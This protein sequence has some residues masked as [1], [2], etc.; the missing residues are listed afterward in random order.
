MYCYH[1]STVHPCRIKVGRGKKE[2]KSFFL[3]CWSLTCL[4]FGNL[5]NLCKVDCV[6]T[7]KPAE[8]TDFLGCLLLSFQFFFHRIHLLS[9]YVFTSHK[10]K[11]ILKMFRLTWFIQFSVVPQVWSLKQ[12][13]HLGMR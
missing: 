8:F 2:N 11:Y 3:V 13:H 6:Q 9:I 5:N 10:V 4:D 12:Q 1:T 7:S